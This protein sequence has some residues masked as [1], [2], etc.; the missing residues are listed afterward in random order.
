MFIM[1]Q[2]KRIILFFKFSFCG[3]YSLHLHKMEQETSHKLKIWKGM[4]FETC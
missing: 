4:F 1:F 2:E 3:D